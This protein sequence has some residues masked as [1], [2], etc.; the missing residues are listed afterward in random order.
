M[1]ALFEKH[2]STERWQLGWGNA[3]IWA[4]KRG[5]ADGADL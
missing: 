1:K 3:G 2:V 4:W 5:E